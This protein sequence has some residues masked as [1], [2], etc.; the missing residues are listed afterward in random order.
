VPERHVY[1]DY[2]Q[3]LDLDEIDLVEILL[4]HHLHHQVTLDA[5]A[6]GKHISLQKPMAFSVEQADEMIDAARRQGVQLKV[7]ENTIFY[8]PY[9]RAKALIE[10]GEIG[11]PI[12]I[13]Q[14]TIAGKSADAWPITESSW[15]WR[16]ERDLAGGGQWLTDDGHHAYSTSWYF[17]GLPEEVHAWTGN[18]MLPS[19]WTVDLPVVASWR[20]PGERFGLWQAVK[21]PELELATSHYAAD[22]VLE[23]IG[24]KGVIWVTRCTGKMLDMPPV[25]LYRDRK[26]QSYS[27][28]PSGWEQSFILSTRHFID[29]LAN[30]TEPLFSGEQGRDMLRWCLAAE[31]SAATGVPVKF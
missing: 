30:D 8:P 5:V 26:T 13:C 14:R 16:R 9:R 25:V 11:E 23:I 20:F 22:D 15:T 24:T 19:G 28:V 27:D 1:A 3:L 2:R 12:T 6:A 10:A 4:P 18:T 29:A 31:E 7:Y 17:F 21:A